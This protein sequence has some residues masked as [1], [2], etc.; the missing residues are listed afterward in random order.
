MKTHIYILIFLI[1]GCSNIAKKKQNISSDILK[2]EAIKSVKDSISL[3]ENKTVILYVEEEDTF[4]FTNGELKQ[5]IKLFPDLN[6]KWP[7]SPDISYNNS[8][9]FNNSNKISKDILDSNGKKETISF[10]SELGQDEYY[11]LYAYFL[12]NKNGDK[13]Y[14]TQRQNLIELYRDINGIFE[15][16]SYGGTYFGHQHR[17]IVGY[18]EYSV[19]LYSGIYK[20]DNFFT[21]KYN[22]TKQKQLYINSLLQ[23]IND[24][25]SVDFNTIDKKGKAERKIKF[26]EKVY[27]I[28]KLISNYFYLKRAQEFQYSHY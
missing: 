22:I 15:G 25:E 21:K 24:K 11:I 3:T 17:R 5:I 16:I 1:C 7:T 28:K 9:P 12:K 10:N 23:L 13:K 19:Y 8:V 18:A 20:N 2:K 6:A 26:L 14:Q 4:S 27:N